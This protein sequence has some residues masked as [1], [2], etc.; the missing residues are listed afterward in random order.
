RIY[1]LPD[2]FANTGQLLGWSSADAVIASFGAMTI[3]KRGTLER[4]TYPYEQS[5][6]IPGIGNVTSNTILSPDGK[7]ICEFSR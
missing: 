4:L 2:R 5:K 6:A 3:L 7:Y 1:R